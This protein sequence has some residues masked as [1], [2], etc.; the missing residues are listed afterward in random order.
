MRGGTGCDMKMKIHTECEECA[1]L[2]TMCTECVQ[3]GLKNVQCVQAESSQPGASRD[4]CQSVSEARKLCKS[5]FNITNIE[6]GRF[7]LRL[8]KKEKKGNEKEI[9]S[10]INLNMSDHSSP[11]KFSKLSAQNSGK[12][13]NQI[14]ILQTL[15]KRKLNDS[16]VARLVCNFSERARNL[17]GDYEFSNIESPAKRRRVGGH[18]GQGQ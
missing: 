13:F 5:T 7:S 18:R 15:Q 11:T 6:G 16:N 8:N 3:T 9:Q 14:P 1:R 10:Q 17:P 4:E 2:H 12:T